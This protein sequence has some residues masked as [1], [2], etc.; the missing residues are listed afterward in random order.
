MK[1]FIC[2]LWFSTFLAPGYAME[3]WQTHFSCGTIWNYACGQHDI[4]YVSDQECICAA[5][6]ISQFSTACAA[7]AASAIAVLGDWFSNGDIANVSVDELSLLLKSIL[8]LGAKAYMNT[9]K[10][11]GFAE[12]GLVAQ[13][14]AKREHL[15]LRFDNERSIKFDLHMRTLPNYTGEQH[16]RTA[17]QWLVDTVEHKEA[18]AAGVVISDGSSSRALLYV[19]SAKGGYFML[20]DSHATFGPDFEARLKPSVVVLSPEQQ[21]K[22][23]DEEALALFSKQSIQHGS[24]LG[25]ARTIDDMI[26]I[27]R[28]DGR[29]WL[30]RDSASL[31]RGL[32][33]V[34]M[35]I[36]PK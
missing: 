11:K 18:L 6:E 24:F 17:A 15:P 13:Y 9:P 30:D 5:T 25:I 20:Y 21:M 32:A 8:Q 22:L 36:K 7:M 4:V 33:T 26:A 29:W 14:L 27:A 28:T 3:I 16:M 31:S 2:F 35:T 1:K 23:T 10:D 19:H 34:F 12:A